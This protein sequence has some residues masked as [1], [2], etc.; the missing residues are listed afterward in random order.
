MT[1]QKDASVDRK[2]DV[3]PIRL[4]MVIGTLGVAVLVSLTIIK[5][6]TGR[7][8]A[9][10]E[11]ASPDNAIVAVLEERSGQQLD[12]NFRVGIRRRDEKDYRWLLNS[13]DEGRPPGSERFLW[14]ADGRYVAL[15]GEHFYVM[16]GSATASGVQLYLVYDCQNNRL[17]CNASQLQAERFPIDALPDIG[18]RL[19][20]L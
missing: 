6:L 18:I 9:R 12:R 7:V 16:E 11:V 4:W 5:S 17:W 3:A 8:P 20:R 1:G 13:P 19:E 10:L 2:K 14:S 15:I